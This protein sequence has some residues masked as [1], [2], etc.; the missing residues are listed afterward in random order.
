[1]LKLQAAVYTSTKLTLIMF[2]TVYT[3]AFEHFLTDWYV[4]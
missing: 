1:M 2:Y 3:L 4:C